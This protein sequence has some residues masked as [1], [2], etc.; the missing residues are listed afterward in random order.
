MNWSMQLYTDIKICWSIF[1]II[2]DCDVVLFLFGSLSTKPQ[3]VSGR[4]QPNSMFGTD[5][6]CSM[7]MAPILPVV[8]VR[9]QKLYFCWIILISVFLFTVCETKRTEPNRS[10]PEPTEP[11]ESRVNVVILEFFSTC[12]H[13]LV[14]SHC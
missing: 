7:N 12:M 4:I 1:T 10:K 5:K 8:T 9:Q 6:C 2:Y 14:I 13:I 3:S 11:F